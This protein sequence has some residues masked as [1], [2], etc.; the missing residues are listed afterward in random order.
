LIRRALVAA[1]ISA[2]LVCC[3]QSPCD[4]LQSICDACPDATT[5]A[6]CNSSLAQY[7][8]G[9]VAG[10]ADCQAA[11]SAHDFASCGG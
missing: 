7:R 3:G 11:I 4:H 8:G 10:D 1:L 6:D 2:A 5:K 9:G